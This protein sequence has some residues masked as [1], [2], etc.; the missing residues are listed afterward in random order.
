MKKNNRILLLLKVPPPYGGGE[1][2]NSYLSQALKNDD[3]FVTLEL[4]SKRRSRV[5]QGHFSAWKVVE[6]VLLF[7]RL[8]FFLVSHRPR[9]V[10][11]RFGKDYSTFLKDSI[12]F[13]LC[14]KLGAGV[15]TELAG[16]RFWVLDEANFIR[17]YALKVLCRVKSIRMLGTNIAD[18]HAQDGLSNIVV[19]DNGS[20][21]PSLS[22]KLNLNSSTVEFIFVGA[23]TKLKGFDTL[24]L[25]A[26]MLRDRGYDFK[27]VSMGN[28]ESESFRREM[29]SLANSHGPSEWF[30][31]LG[32]CTGKSKW[33]VY[34]NA[35]VLVLPSHTEGQPMCVLE[36]FGFGLAVIAS[37]V[38]GVPDIVE[39]GVNGSL[40]PPGDAKAL[41]YAMEKFIISKNSIKLISKNNQTLFLKRFTVSRYVENT[42]QW[43]LSIAP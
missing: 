1:V 42:R 40:V 32:L 13:W 9:L 30:H 12:L 33:D 24:I 16:E 22:R 31:P 37:P 43:L 34:Q 21:I 18:R 29:Y 10:Y 11:M 36:A 5:T 27:L 28:W 38:G 23:H 7:F 26:C 41:S 25:A 17:Q 14:D 3:E 2:I 20:Y 19:M 6:F 35:Q 39:E 8:L 4:I 15:A